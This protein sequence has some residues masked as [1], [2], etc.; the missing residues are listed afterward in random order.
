MYNIDYVC[1]LGFGDEGKG[2]IAAYLATKYDEENTITVLCSGS[3]QRGHTMV[4]ENGVRHVFHHFGCA[5]MYG[6]HNYIDHMFY[7][8]PIMFRKEWEELE[9]KG[10]TPVVYMNKYTNL[11]LPYHMLADQCYTEIRREADDVVDSSCGCGVWQARTSTLFESQREDGVVVNECTTLATLIN[12]RKFDACMKHFRNGTLFID[13]IVSSA[14]GN[15]YSEIIKKYWDIINNDDVWEHYWE[16]LNFMVEHCTL[17]DDIENIKDAGYNN[18]IVELSQGIYLDND[19]A[20][21]SHSTS[22]NTRPSAYMNL[23]SSLHR[24]DCRVTVNFVTRWYLT[25]HGF[26]QNYYGQTMDKEPEFFGI[27]TE[28]MNETNV[29]NEWQGKFNYDA[30]SL[31]RIRYAINNERSRFGNNVTMRAFIT[32]FD[33]VT[34]KI[35]ISNDDPYDEEAYKCLMPFEFLQQFV[36][37]VKNA[38]GRGTVPACYVCCGEQPENIIK[39]RKDM[40]GGLK[41]Y[42]SENHLH[43][44]VHS[45]NYDTVL[46]GTGNTIRYTTADGSDTVRFYSNAADYTL[47]TTSADSVIISYDDAVRTI[48]YDDVVSNHNN[49]VPLGRLDMT[50]LV[51]AYARLSNA[52]SSTTA[53]NSTTTTR[54]HF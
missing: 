16:D 45:I 46:G 51:D 23:L 21:D 40:I 39:L 36:S 5:T 11:V 8:N 37:S 14:D 1:G 18:Y 44:I 15:V 24:A 3:S 41:Q 33:Q 4:D 2:R 20:A 30:L 43:D 26:N 10:I 53:S 17:V 54:F 28:V 34:N 31:E 27:N 7:S 38:C 22:C 13:R 52:C 32:C 9:S 47:T 25:R 6:Y 42:N 19:Y 48:N 50:S 12:R 49:A 29:Y 35:Y